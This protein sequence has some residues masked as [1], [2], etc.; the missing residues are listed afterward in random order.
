VAVD[1][2]HLSWPTSGDHQTAGFP[3]YYSTWIPRLATTSAQPVRPSLINRASRRCIFA[4]GSLLLVRITFSERETCRITRSPAV[5]VIDRHRM[6]SKYFKECIGLPCCDCHF[7]IASRA[8][9][10]SGSADRMDRNRHKP[11]EWLLGGYQ[12]RLWCLAS[13]Q[14]IVHPREVM[15]STRPTPMARSTRSGANSRPIPGWWCSAIQ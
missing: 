8:W 15:L 9:V 3:P 10:E 4:R 2:L 14:R 12:S 1:G 7:S 11:G 5:Y 13:L 6:L